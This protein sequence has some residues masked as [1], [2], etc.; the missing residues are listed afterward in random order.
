[1]LHGILYL[2]I[3]KRSKGLAQGKNEKP[4]EENPEKQKCNKENVV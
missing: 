2:T 4:D 3:H 1:M